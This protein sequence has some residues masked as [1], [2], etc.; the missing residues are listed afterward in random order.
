MS[1]EKLIKVRYEGQ[2]PTKI[3]CKS[4]KG[5]MHIKKGDPLELTEKEL[6]E[7]ANLKFVKIKNRRG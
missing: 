2:V 5:W 4:S 1:E 3:L 7:L 6:T